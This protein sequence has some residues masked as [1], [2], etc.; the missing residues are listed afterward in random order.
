VSRTSAEAEFDAWLAELSSEARTGFEKELPEVQ[1]RIQ[2]RFDKILSEKRKRYVRLENVLR[3]LG[4]RGGI[5]W[6]N[7]R[8]AMRAAGFS[9]DQLAALSLRAVVETLEER[10]RHLDETKAVGIRNDSPL[11]WRAT[12]VEGGRPEG[13]KA[14]MKIRGDLFRARRD[15]RTLAGFAKWLGISKTT[16]RRI[17]VDHE[18]SEKTL[19]RIADRRGHDFLEDL[20]QGKNQS[21]KPKS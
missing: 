3:R 13:S 16:Y 5:T 17:E 8:K 4:F 9:V 20:L 10:A 11:F 14:V 7:L 6:P 21:K 2:E 15:Q 18:A 19:N 1:A 12:G